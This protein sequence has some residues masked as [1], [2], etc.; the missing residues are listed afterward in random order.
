MTAF[1]LNG[2][3]VDAPDDLNLLEYLREEAR[4]T[5]VKNGCSEGA[6]GA[7][8]VL[9]DGKAQRA[10]LFKVSRLEG[11]SVL[12]VEGLSDRE[13][14]VFAH[15]FGEAGAV[16]CGFCIPGM[17][18]SAKALLDKNPAPSRAEIKEAIK[19]NVCRCTGYVKIEK[20]VAM[21]AEYWRDGLKQTPDDHQKLAG[22]LGEPIHRVDAA[23]KVLGLGLYTDD[24]KLPGM[25]YGRALR[26]AAPRVLI[27]KI[28]VDEA[29]KAP[30]VIAVMLAGDIP[31][32]RFLGHLPH[33]HDWPALIAEGEETRYIGDALALVAAESKAAANAAL[34]LIKVDYEELKPLS[35]PR[36]ALAEDAPKIH[37]RGNILQVEKLYRGH[38]EEAIKNSR[39]VVSNT[40]ELPFT[41]HAF[42]EPEC[43][44][45]LP[46]GDGVML[47]TGGQSVYDERRECA[48]VLGLPPE[49]VRVRSMLV[50]GGFGGK[51][52]M[53][54][55][56]HAAL[57]AWKTRAPVKV[58]L[59]RQESINIHP[60]RHAMNV[61]MTTACDEKGRLTA[62]R[63]R[64]VAD[65]GAYASLGGPVLQRACTHAA[66]PY[67]YQNVDIIGTAVYT[68]NPPG[69]AF[70]GFGV[71]QTVYATECNLNQL[72][73][74]A[75]L[76]DWKI[77]HLN[78]L[79]PGDVMPNG[80]IADDGTAL[81]ETLLSVKEEYE[82]APLAGIACAL[83]NS[84]VGVGLPDAGRCRLEI[85]DGQAHVFTS[86]ACI[87]QG[88]ATVLTQMVATYAG[89]DCRQITV[90]PPDTKNSPDSGTTTASRQTLFTGEAARRA[91]LKLKEALAGRDLAEL[92][93]REFYAEYLGETD[94][95]GS[96][97]ANPVSHI[98]Y[99]YA[100]HLVLMNPENGLIEK[101]IAVHDVGRVVNPQALEGQI[102]GGVVT[103]L[104]YALTEDYPLKD[105]V[106]QA[107]FASLGLFK[108]PAVPPIETRYLGKACSILAG[109][110]KGVGEISAIPAA[111]AVQGAY[112]KRDGLFR[113][114]LPLENT[115]YSRKNPAGA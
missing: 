86:A 27:K 37:P 78:A 115:P 48:H 88:M 20:A 5:S 30:G 68:N 49:K 70:R 91:A 79:R 8:M 47:Y 113:A 65:T 64:V 85:I 76:S 105:C 11:K 100:T 95:M 57:L 14:N 56:H 80:Q 3:K 13:K 92:E 34:K 42:L 83:K 24:L 82:K 2:L 50:G 46:D 4:L 25:L 111:P 23:A 62:M 102:E 12:T 73:A 97:K 40:F 22:L 55:Q 36:L 18:M 72:A 59:T 54:V 84:G 21:A 53:S 98:A 44:V 96:P 29:K 104:G 51:E 69:G 89:L 66:G 99:G 103:S 26:P 35:S 45:A 15:V 16:Q 7:C 33:T 39:Y 101:I 108:A 107:K 75:G 52:D 71:T 114:K 41:E 1:I 9:V 6:C 81:E 106:P 112:Y 87:G 63:C 109:G 60:K 77:R 58:L 38:P 74:L 19:F 110:A 31:G 90:A 43:A 10:C 32:Q 93:G 94:P 17:V 67:N 61:E 28:D